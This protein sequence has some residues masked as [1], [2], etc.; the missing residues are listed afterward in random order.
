M[1]GYFDKNVNT[2]SRMKK[3]LKILKIWK[4]NIFDIKD[5][6]LRTFHTMLQYRDGGD[7]GIFITLVSKVS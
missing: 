7:I 3:E 4:R 5:N 6:L 1:K 2:K